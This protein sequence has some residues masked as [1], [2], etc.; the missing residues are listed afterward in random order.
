MVFMRPPKGEDGSPGGWTE[1]LCAQ[2]ATGCQK[3]DQKK[4][5]CPLVGA[6][7]RP[8]ADGRTHRTEPFKKN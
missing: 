1:S 2:E 8:A 7:A 5:F 6:S 3:K 4:S